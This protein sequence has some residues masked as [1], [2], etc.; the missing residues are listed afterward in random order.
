MC[1]PELL[2]AKDII[3]AP[4]VVVGEQKELDLGA[5]DHW[6]CKRV[7]VDAKLF[8]R[9]SQRCIRGPSYLSIRFSTYCLDLQ[10]LD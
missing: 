9:H 7:R 6:P 3:R 5:E 8:I 4:V 10:A 1:H 2:G